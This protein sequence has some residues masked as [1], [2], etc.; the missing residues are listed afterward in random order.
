[1]SDDELQRKHLAAL[2]ERDGRIARHLIAAQRSIFDM[3]E[4]Q[5]PAVL[6][7]LLGYIRDIKQVAPGALP[8]RMM[9][10]D[11]YIAYVGEAL[12]YQRKLEHDLVGGITGESSRP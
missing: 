3:V 1:M 9:L 8:A 7:A 4:E 12:K 11:T 6:E 10:R 5:S 2:K